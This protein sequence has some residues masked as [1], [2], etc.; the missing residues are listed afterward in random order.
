VPPAGPARV[1]RHIRLLDTRDWF[2]GVDPTR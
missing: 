2:T 1:D